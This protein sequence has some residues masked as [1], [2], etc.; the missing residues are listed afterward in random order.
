MLSMSKSFRLKFLIGLGAFLIGGYIGCRP[1]Q[2]Q[3]AYAKQQYQQTNTGGY[4]QS[5]NG[6]T[7]L[8]PPSLDPNNIIFLTKEMWLIDTSG[9]WVETGSVKGYTAPDGVSATTYWAGEYY[10]RQ[11]IVN[12]NPVYQRKYIGSS[13]S[14][15]SKVFQVNVGQ[16]SGSSYSWDFYLNNSYVGSFDSPSSSFPYAQI[17]IETN[18][19][20]SNYSNGTYVDS[21]YILTPSK[22]WAKWGSSVVDAD[23]KKIAAWDS[24]YSSTNQRIIFN[25]G[26]KPTNCP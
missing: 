8:S 17:G 22:T 2:A 20:C 15:G 4:F 25:S 7:D 16:A 18:N 1:I 26:A 5:V 6:Q 23:N 19:G 10:A 9:N 14:T 11:K 13:G 12:G 24:V 3:R 21:M